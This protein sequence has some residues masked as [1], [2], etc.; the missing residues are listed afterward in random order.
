MPV[1]ALCIVIGNGSGDGL[2]RLLLTAVYVVWR[3]V[4]SEL[5]GVG[6]WDVKQGLLT[7]V[8]FE[9]SNCR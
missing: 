6:S 2:N 5:L 8:L 1:G 7:I 9:N 4:D 3:D